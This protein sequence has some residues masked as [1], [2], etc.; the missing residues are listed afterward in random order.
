MSMRAWNSQLEADLFDEKEHVSIK[1]I[2]DALP[3]GSAITFSADQLEVLFSG[4]GPVLA[5]TKTRAITNTFGYSLALHGDTGTITKTTSTA[6]ASAQVIVPRSPIQIDFE[7]EKEDKMFGKS[8]GNLHEEDKFLP[9]V[10]Q[11]Q[12]LAP[13]HLAASDAAANSS[14]GPEM[15][16]VGE[17]SSDGSVNVFG[18]VEG[19]LHASIGGLLYAVDLRRPGP[20]VVFLTGPQ[21]LL[22]LGDRSGNSISIIARGWPQIACLD[23]FGDQI[24]RSCWVGERDIVAHQSLS[25]QRQV[26]MAIKRR[27]KRP[28]RA[29]NLSLTRKLSLAGVT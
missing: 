20:L 5:D 13:T 7:D 8:K 21:I 3:N 12:N 27:S 2:L 15:T 26:C 18:H 22:Q 14:I 6:V 16:V 23:K 10:Q 11:L 25:G 4:G 9:P 28:Q 29:D 17:L 19:E 24:L 1:K